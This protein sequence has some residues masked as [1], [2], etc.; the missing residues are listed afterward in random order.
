MLS[1]FRS[2][3]NSKIGAWVVALIGIGILAGFAMGDISNF[4]TGISGL[5][6]SSD[7]LAKIGDQIV[8]ERELSDVLQRRLQAARQQQPNADYASIIGDFNP[9]LGELIDQRGLM[10][11]ADKFGFPISKRLVDAEIAQ[12]PAAKG[13]NGQV[14][15]QSYQ[16]FLQQQHLTDAQVR[17]LITGELLQKLILTPV[18]TNAHIPVGMA[19]PYASMLLEMREGEAAIVPADA[20]KAGLKPSEAQLQQ[21]YAANKSVRYMI[22]EQRVLRIARIGPEQV[23]NVTASDKEIS[24]YYSQHKDQ[25]AASDTR[26]LSQVVVQ[27]QATANAIAQRARAGQTLAAAAASAGPNAAAST[28]KDQTKSAYAGVAGDQ[29]A[30]AV[31]SAADGAVVGPIKSTFGWAVVKI[32]SVKSTPAKTL[33][34]ARS[35][36]A[37]KLNVDKRKGAI[38][39]MVDKVQ[40][41]LDQ[42]SNFNEAVAAAKLPVTTTPLINASGASRADPSFKL[43]PELVPVLKSGFEIAPND[44]PEVVTLPGTA[45][46][47][48]VSPGQVVPAAPAPLESIRDQVSNDWIADQ[49]MQ[50]ARAAAVQIAAKASGNVSL[51]DAIK[52]VGVTIPPPRPIAARRLQ[53]ADQQGNVVPA[54]RVLFTTPAGKAQIGG[55]PQADGYFVV[56]VNKITPGNAFMAASLIGQV[57]GDIGRSSQLDYAQQFVNDIKR[58]LKV[59]RN[60]SAIQ[61][62]RTR[63]LSSGS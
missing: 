5:G 52:A 7:T 2:I 12:I 60:E 31:F 41:A 44:P 48:V 25:F 10:A 30:A 61:A 54:M 29:A 27:D 59:K 15:D 57:S 63:L 45:G 55:N 40:N 18:A 39:D 19:T 32:D 23:A 21:F 58:T 47:A 22:P 56:K 3:A 28:L 33:E 17:V 11:F 16:A 14:T 37:D 53:M 26:S 38:E 35:E 42:G 4:G 34:Q 50:R 24:D 51:A 49:A 1:F 62:F 36:I 6:M 13:I 9:L 43:P 20:F 46:Y 8:T